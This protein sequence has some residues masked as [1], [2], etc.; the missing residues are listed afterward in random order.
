MLHPQKATDGQPGTAGLSILRCQALP[1]TV[2]KPGMLKSLQT[3]LLVSSA[4]SRAA[5]FS[6]GLQSEM[7]KKKPKPWGKYTPSPPMPTVPVPEALRRKVAPSSKKG[8]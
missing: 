8:L 2:G 5:R 6:A 1:L 3:A 7:T 4:Q